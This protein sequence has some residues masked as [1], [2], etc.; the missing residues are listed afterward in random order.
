MKKVFSLVS[1]VTLLIA[2][3]IFL[4]GCF[5]DESAK[6]KDLEGELKVLAFDE[7]RAK[8]FLAKAK[9][10]LAAYEKT[11]ADIKKSEAIVKQLETISKELEDIKN[12]TDELRA[13][14]E[15]TTT[16]FQQ[17]QLDNRT[18]VRKAIIGEEVDLSSVKGEGFESVRVLSVNPLGIRIYTSSGPEGVELKDLP[19]ELRERLL[20]DEEEAQAYRDRLAAN[21]ESRA[22]K[23]EEWKKGLSERKE[24]AAQEAIAQRLKDIQTEVEGLEKQINLRT[25]KIRDLKSR[26][27][28][29]ERNWSKEVNKARRAKA[30]KYYQYYRDQAQ[31]VTDENSNAYVVIFRLRA[32]MEDLK[33]LKKP[34]R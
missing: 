3:S 9:D 1:P 11:R 12:E 8:E 20:M 13:S 4:S 22:K 28:Q 32:E 24:E 15:S 31:L 21:A 27:S 25:N 6:I 14:F 5:E 26:A 7:K 29:W 10:K 17:Y 34:A 18:K 16:E 23:Y 19:T 30:E 2:A 33:A